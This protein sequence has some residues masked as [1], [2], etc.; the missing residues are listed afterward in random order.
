MTAKKPTD[1]PTAKL[2]S[3]EA[4]YTRLVQKLPE[5]KDWQYEI[6][7]DGYRCLAGRG[8][9]GVT[10]WSRR[11]NLFTTQFPKIAQACT[12]LKPGTLLDGE[13]VAIDETG[14]VSF[15]ILQNRRSKASAIR[16]YVFDL[17]MYCGK[18]LLDVPLQARRELLV[19]ALADITRSADSIRL[20]EAMEAKP[21][22]LIAAAKEMRLEGLIAKRKDSLY[23]SGKRSGAWVK[24]KLNKSQEFVIGG[25]THGNP[26]DALVAGYYAN[27]QLLYA[28]KVRNGFVPQLRRDVAKRF[29]GWRLTLV[30]LPTCRRRGGRN[31]R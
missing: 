3:I 12:R 24:Y 6:K 28:A 10:L 16:Y 31:G 7:F 25:Y 4:M 17:I 23:E 22:D 9:S 5:G 1:P 30:R 26:L 21:A 11:K 2:R 8:E 19:D 20:S 14:Y 29:R 15:N 27:G 18:S 13:I